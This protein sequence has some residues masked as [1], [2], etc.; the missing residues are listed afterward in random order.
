MAAYNADDWIGAARYFEEMLLIQPDHPE[1]T[2]RLEQIR[3]GLGTITFLGSD[4]VVYGISPLGGEPVELFSLSG[5]YPSVLEWS[6]DGKSI[7]YISERG[8]KIIVVGYDGSQPRTIVEGPAGDFEDLAWSPDQGRIAFTRYHTGGIW[9]VRV[10]GGT[11]QPLGCAANYWARNVSWS[12]DGTTIVF[13]DCD[14][15]HTLATDPQGANCRILTDEDY[16]DFIWSPSGEQVL[17]MDPFPVGFLYLS[18]PDGS[19]MRGLWADT[20]YPASGHA[21]AVWSPDGKYFAFE[22]HG[23]IYVVPRHVDERRGPAVD[24]DLQSSR[25]SQPL[26]TRLGKLD[27]EV[28]PPFLLRAL[29]AS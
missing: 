14:Q 25:R 1:A 24:T 19:G 18:A 9:Y 28:A 11:P 27:Y 10:E 8:D 3:Q 13:D 12:P 20:L 26:F 23:N 16:Y 2:T 21:D 22:A 5:E 7:A 17:A 4:D 15:S 6:P 29:P